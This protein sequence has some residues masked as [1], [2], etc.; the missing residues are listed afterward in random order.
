MHLFV[1]DVVRDDAEDRAEVHRDPSHLR[2]EAAWHDVI[3]LLRERLRDQ[4][5]QSGLGRGDDG[6]GLDRATAPRRA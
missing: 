2:P 6:T 5:G 1:G 3:E 4:G